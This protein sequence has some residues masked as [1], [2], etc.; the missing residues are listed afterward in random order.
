MGMVLWASN[1]S[2]TARVLYQQQQCVQGIEHQAQ[3]PAAAQ[4][5]RAAPVGRQH[6]QQ[7]H[8]YLAV[9]LLPQQEKG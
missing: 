2:S 7:M 8:L 5:L 9:G 3:S 4:R 1:S 6:Q